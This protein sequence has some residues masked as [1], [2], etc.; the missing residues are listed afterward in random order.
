MTFRDV[1]VIDR[2]NPP[3]GIIFQLIEPLEELDKKRG[4]QAAEQLAEFR[5]EVFETS[6]IDIPMTMV[7]MENVKEVT[8][9]EQTDD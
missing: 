6:G 5:Q 1:I 4:Y 9:P 3:A 2:D 7:C 8:E